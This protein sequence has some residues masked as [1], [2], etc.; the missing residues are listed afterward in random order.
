MKDSTIWLILTI[1]TVIILLMGC[2]NRQTWT[3]TVV[4]DMLQ[5]VKTTTLVYESDTGVS[6]GTKGLGEYNLIKLEGS[7][8][9]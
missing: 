2:A 6:I 9:Q 8:L 5:K 1:G 7:G 4:E 3:K